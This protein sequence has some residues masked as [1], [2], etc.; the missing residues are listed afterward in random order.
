MYDLE[1]TLVAR[2]L[3]VFNDATLQD[4]LSVGLAEGPG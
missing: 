4:A 1:I 2:T 3:P